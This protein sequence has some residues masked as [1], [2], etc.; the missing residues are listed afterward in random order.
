MSRRVLAS[1]V[2]TTTYGTWLPG[3]TRGYVDHGRILPANPPKH[4]ANRDRMHGPTV[5]L[6]SKQQ[7]VVFQALVDAS[8]EFHYVLLDAAVEAWHL[9]WIVAHGFDAMATV[10]RRLK[11]RMRQALGVGRLWT[12]GYLAVPLYTEHTLQAKRAYI[13]RHA[14]CRMMAGELV[15]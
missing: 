2:T 5:H 1:F 4:R 9:H 3:D 11:N 12:R 10:V 14:G 13:A 6:T 8:H 7:D 15:N